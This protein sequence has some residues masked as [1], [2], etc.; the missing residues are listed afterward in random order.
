[1]ASLVEISKLLDEKLD[2]KFATARKEI[3]DEL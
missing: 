3:V 1:M 2:T